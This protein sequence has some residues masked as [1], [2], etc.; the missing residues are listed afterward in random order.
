MTRL[1][2]QGCQDGE[3]MLD[4]SLRLQVPVNELMVYSANV[5]QTV[6]MT[7][8]F[9]QTGF[10]PIPNRNMNYRGCRRIFTTWESCNYEFTSHAE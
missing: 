10:F 9:M 8:E 5:E 4:K 3:A 7:W 2:P 6:H 1:E